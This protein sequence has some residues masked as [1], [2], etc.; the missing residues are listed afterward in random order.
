MMDSPSL[1]GA[2]AGACA[3]T[4]GMAMV[5]TRAA[6]A[7]R[8][9]GVLAM[10]AVYLLLCFYVCDLEMQESNLCDQKML[11]LSAYI[12]ALSLSLSQPLDLAGIP[13]ACC[14]GGGPRSHGGPLLNF[15]PII[16]QSGMSFLRLA[17]SAF[18]CVCSRLAAKNIKMARRCA[19]H[20]HF[21]CWTCGRI[22]FISWNLCFEE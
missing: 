18:L 3:A 10:A 7:T 12:T 13:M 6:A 22:R 8:P 20:I 14:A 1:V 11:L 19:E 2:G 16:F 5:K 9:N 21:F 4:A 17:V 15:F